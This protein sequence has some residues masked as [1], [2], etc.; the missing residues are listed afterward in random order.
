MRI[1]HEKIS[2]IL[3]KLTI[4]KFTGREETV[5]NV[6]DPRAGVFFFVVQGAFEVQYRLL[7]SRDGLS[8]WSTPEI[9]LEAL[10]NDAIILAVEVAIA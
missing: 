4:G 8:L 9:E 10:S 5:Y 6:S 7:E 3:P 2:F 1:P